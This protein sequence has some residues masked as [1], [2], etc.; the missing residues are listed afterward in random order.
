MT[1]DTNYNKGQCHCARVQLTKQH[2]VFVAG[3]V[4]AASTF[5]SVVFGH[6]HLL[7]FSGTGDGDGLQQTQ[8]QHTDTQ[9]V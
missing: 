5:T 3:V 8:R 4:A 6:F 9:Q 1:I 2:A 7:Q